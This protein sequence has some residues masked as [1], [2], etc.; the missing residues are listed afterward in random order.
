MITFNNFTVSDIKKI[1]RDYNL[2]HKI[3]TKGLKKEELI[4]HIEKYLYIDDNKIKE[5]SINK[6]YDIPKLIKTDKP[7]KSV[8]LNK[9]KKEEVKQIEEPKIKEVIK[10]IELLKKEEDKPKKEEVKKK[11]EPKTNY[12]SFTIEQLNNELDKLENIYGLSSS[13]KQMELDDTL[14]YIERLISEKKNKII[15]EEIY[16][17]KLRKE[18]ELKKYYEK[19]REKSNKMDVKFDK[20]YKPKKK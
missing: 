3:I 18:E 10:I 1:I 16:K 4:S 5:H 14:D 2:H 19:V 12:E 6:D 17:N 11:E 8:K 15:D 9:P 20:T 13:K 7:K